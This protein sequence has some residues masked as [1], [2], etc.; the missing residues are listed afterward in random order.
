MS[1]A[2]VLACAYLGAAWAGPQE[3][4]SGQTTT[5]RV[6]VNLTLVQVTV[7]DSLG[8][9]VIGLEK[10][11]FHLLVDDAEH[12]ISLF[13]NDDAPVS[14]GIL[15]DNSASML[16]KGQEVLAGSLAFAGA[17]NP[18]DQ[19]FVVHFSDEV[20]FGLPPD[21]GFT[22]TIAEL[23]SALTHFNPAGTTALYDAVVQAL[24][25]FRYATLQNRMLLII[26]D[27]GDNSSQAKLPD[28]L[29]LA[30]E[31]GCVIYS[32]GI[33]DETDRDRNPA[34]L[35][36]LADSTGGSTFFPSTL[37]EVTSTCVKIAQQ[38]RRQYTLGFE[39]RED[40]QYHTI[41]VKIEDPRGGQFKVRARAGY[42]APKA[43]AGTV[44]HP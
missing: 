42:V 14:A 10:P 23:E 8:H 31:C 43:S 6:D 25:H 38:I 30:Q 24:S 44:P 34:A 36:Q 33:Y 40:G 13:Q 29:K 11:V 7:V 2:L 19:L 3:L 17:S 41:T 22:G 32:I 16:S 12:D 18:H 1:K 5:L 15:V 35:T 4:P 21:K 26:S 9:P 20:R 39:G 27:G 37:N 28:V